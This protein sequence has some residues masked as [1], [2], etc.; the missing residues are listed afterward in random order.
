MTYNAAAALNKQ[1]KNVQSW[2]PLK[3]H[4]KVRN[5]IFWV[6]QLKV[7]WF[8]VELHFVKKVRMANEYS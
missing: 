6:E 3:M 1:K 8:K 5:V 7:E 2:R 4:K